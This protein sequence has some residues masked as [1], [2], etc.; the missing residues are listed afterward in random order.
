MKEDKELIKKFQYAFSGLLT[1]LRSDRS[2][3]LQFALAALAVVFFRFLSLSLNEWL[4]VFSAIFMVL[5]A[6]FFNSVIEH[7]SD[8]IEV[9]YHPRI[10]TIKDMSAA[11]VL[12]AAFY[13]VIVAITIGVGKLR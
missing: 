3:Q 5:V 12:L 6:E 7:I 2:I 11:A 8:M 4:F 10:K 1:G 9:R 13:A